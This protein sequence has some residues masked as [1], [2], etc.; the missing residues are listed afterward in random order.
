MVSADS[1]ALT[2][3]GEAAVLDDDDVAISVRDVSKAYRVYDRPQ[4]RLWESLLLGRR[5]FSRDFQALQPLSFEVR[6]GETVGIIGRNGSGKSTLLQTICGTLTPTTGRIETRGRVAALL[7]LGAGFSPEFTGRENVRLYAATVGLSRAELEARFDGILEF[8]DIGAFIDQPVRTYSSGMVVRLAFAVLAN[9]DAD[10]LVID[11]ALA[12]GDV[13]FVQKCMRWLRGFMRRGTLLF[14]SHDTAS[15]V[16]LCDRAIWLHHGAMVMDDSARLVV[17]TYLQSVAE[18]G[19][20]TET[21][22]TDAVVQEVRERNQQGAG[23]ALKETA[24]AAETAP[25]GRLDWRWTDLER[26]SYGQG[27][28]RIG[29]VALLDVHDRVIQSIRGGELLTLR[30]RCT[31]E[32]DLVSPI[33]G[34]VV[35]DRLGQTLFGDNT[36]ERYKHRALRTAAGAQIEARFTFA[37]PILA[38]GPYAIDV[39]IADGTQTDHVQHHWVHEAV[40]FTSVTNHV[41]TGLIGLPMHDVSLSPLGR[42]AS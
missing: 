11:E 16:N 1:P 38:P 23:P 14:V 18:A 19:A 4:D 22:L 32:G 5:R 39:A 27:R 37:V 34:F 17:E 9:I 20:S 6:R 10:V 31:A 35:K 24:A 36:F 3:R 13:F 30:I 40:A 25:S 28:A 33:V 7:E 12:V 21:D 41:A 2:A 8:A 26:R 42:E 29:D 15:V